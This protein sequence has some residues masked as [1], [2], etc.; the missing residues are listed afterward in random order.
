[1][2]SIQKL[3]RRR[4]RANSGTSVNYQTVLR[5][6]T[7]LEFPAVPRAT[8]AREEIPADGLTCSP[9]FEA[10]AREGR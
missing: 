5:K 8:K 7:F 9:G 4:Y 3:L 10:D 2:A 1:V 6:K